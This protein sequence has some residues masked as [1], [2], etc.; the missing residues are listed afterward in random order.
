M[1]NGLHMI[2]SLLLVLFMTYLIMFKLDD[3]IDLFLKTLKNSN[4]TKKVIILLLI[5]LV[6]SVIL[7]SYYYYNKR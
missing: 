6:L 2:A 5:L 1:F 7:F 4:T 3:A